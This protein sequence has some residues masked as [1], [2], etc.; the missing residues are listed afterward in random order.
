M[1]NQKRALIIGAGIA[2]LTCAYK[3][4]TECENIKPI[5]I[6][7]N[8]DIGGLAT[9]FNYD[10]NFA[11]IGPHRFFTKNEQ[12]MQFWES[13]MPLQ[14]EKAL[15][16]IILGRE[17]DFGYGCANPEKQDNVFL[18]RRRF[19]RIFY[20]KK[21]F[22]YPVKLNFK[23]IINLGL[24]RTMCCGFSYIKS[25]IIKRKEESLED[26]MINRFG[27]VLYRTFFEFYT[28]K[29]WG[30][31][32]KN[33]DKSWGQQRIKGLSLLKTLM[34]KLL[35]HKEISLTEEYYYPKY[36]A[37]QMCSQMLKTILEKG[38]EIYFGTEVVKI[39]K[40][41][42][43]IS[44]LTVKNKEGLNEIPADYVVSSMA[45]KDLVCNI[46]DVDKNVYE[47][48]EGL[49][50]R[51]YQLITYLV[52]DFNLKNS[53]D[54]KTINNICPDSWIYVQDREVKIGRIY[55]PK[56]FSPYLCRDIDDTLVCLEY[57]CNKGDKLWNM[58]D[59]EIFEY[60]IEEM[61]CI[62]ALKSKDDVIKSYRLKVE[63]AYPAY[64]DTYEFFDQIKSYINSIDNLYC[65]GRNGQ[66]KYNNMDH[67]TLSGI[68][69]ADIIKNNS[70]KN[71]LWSV[72][73]ECSY[74][75]TK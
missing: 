61:K 9:T 65:I 11:D 66:H 27:K 13:L 1:K 33:I 28:E 19:S 34:N 45:V 25:C 56:N 69:A 44:S 72:N 7:K 26:F 37:K 10:G 60:G 15:D 20:L 67:S 53:T 35:K 64:F 71:L 41:D 3:L 68:I 24:F 58:S 17:L 52:K 29:V 14:G 57:F 5:I 47:I 36:G 40:T 62:N 32:P 70:D 18:K 30:R 63:K 16:D 50:Y 73:T 55:I 21:F 12:V 46:S 48:A 23:T 39:N 74:Q 22:D 38:G 51:D 43:K 59:E 6:E 31:N 4:V 2:G 54:W 49:P 8:A 75:E 42:N